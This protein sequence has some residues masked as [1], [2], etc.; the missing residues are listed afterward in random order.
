MT[1]GPKLTEAYS[2]YLCGLAMKR[3]DIIQ[4]T[5]G[6]FHEFTT[7]EQAAG[8]GSKFKVVTFGRGDS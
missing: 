1:V 6:I 7:V 2:S 3:Q 5:P 4:L 8:E